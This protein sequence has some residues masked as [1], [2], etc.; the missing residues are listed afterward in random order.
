MKKIA[1]ILSFGVILLGANGCMTESVVE[2]A[3]GHPELAA[4]FW[5]TEV[6]AHPQR[7]PADY[8]LLPLTIPADAATAPLLITGYF[9]QDLSGTD[10]V[11]PV[12]A[13]MTTR[14]PF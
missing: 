11:P 4:W 14:A 9:A 7:H 1:L 13:A 2:H 10:H 3:R 12:W 5:T 8:F 6:P